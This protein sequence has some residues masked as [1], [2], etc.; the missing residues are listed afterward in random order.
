MQRQSIRSEDTLHIVECTCSN[1]TLKMPLNGFQ[2]RRCGNSMVKRAMAEPY[3]PKQ[4][5]WV[6][7][8]WGNFKFT[9]MNVTL[10]QNVLG[11]T[12]IYVL[13]SL[14]TLLNKYS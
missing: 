3:S 5:K 7:G 12:Y 14:Q 11:K 6:S 10:I 4:P 2:A 9:Q 1:E 13:K 8:G